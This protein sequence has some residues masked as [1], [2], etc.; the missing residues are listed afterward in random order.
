MNENDLQRAVAKVLDYSGLVWF[1]PPMEGFRS[2]RTGGH[3][4]A[5][6]MKAGICDCLI[7]TPFVDPG[8]D[9]SDRDLNAVRGYSFAGLALE[10]KVGK[11]KPTTSQLEWRDK[12]VSCGWRWE[13]CYSVDEVLAVLR[14]CYPGK[15]K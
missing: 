8:D 10:L 12:L 14:E 3:M 1:H 11:N 9:E 6:G 15:V 5:K 4:K 7:F 2:P 13:C